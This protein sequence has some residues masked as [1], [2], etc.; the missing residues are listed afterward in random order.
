MRKTILLPILL[1]FGITTTLSAQQMR[2]ERIRAFR[3]AVFVEELQLTE[4]E[5]A[6][7]FPVYNAFDQEQEE[8]KKELRKARRNIELVADEDVKT[9]IERMFE[10]EEQQIEL[11]RKYFDRFMEVLPVRKVLR[12]HK[13]EQEFRK[14][15]LEKL[16]ERRGN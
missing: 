3:A 13:A 16:K 6:D 7:F 2:K 5:S 10:V 12:I 4:Q 15:L 8:L 9:H 1:V 14:L 11:K